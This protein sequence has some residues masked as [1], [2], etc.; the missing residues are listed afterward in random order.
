[1]KYE[2]RFKPF[3][4]TSVSLGRRV[5]VEATFFARRST[6]QNFHNLF[7]D[8]LVWNVDGKRDL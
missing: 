4:N 3:L 5:L 2:L 7:F 6:Y 8:N 1:M